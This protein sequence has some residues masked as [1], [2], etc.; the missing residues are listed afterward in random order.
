M[1]R[2]DW[3]GASVSID[4][5]PQGE[6]GRG[7]IALEYSDGR[8]QPLWYPD[9]GRNR[10]DIAGLTAR[11]QALHGYDD[12]PPPKVAAEMAARAATM[13]SSW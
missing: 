9:E 6:A 1:Q 4:M 12:S 7:V 11:F 13:R 3:D 8:I 10:V 2:A 5:A